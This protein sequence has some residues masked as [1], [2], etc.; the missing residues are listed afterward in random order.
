MDGLSHLKFHKNFIAVS[1]ETF[2]ST[3]S[4]V[5]SVILRIFLKILLRDYFIIPSENPSGRLLR[6]PSE[7]IPSRSSFWN[8]LTGYTCDF[9]STSFRVSPKI[10]SK[11]STEDPPPLMEF[12]SFHYWDSSRIF[13]R[14]YSRCFTRDFILDSCRVLYRY[15]SENQFGIPLA[16]PPKVRAWIAYE[17]PPGDPSEISSGILVFILEIIPGF[18]QELLL[19]L[20][21]ELFPGLL[22]ELLP[23][24]L[25]GSVSLVPPYSLTPSWIP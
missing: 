22:Q 18:L 21:Q 17:I 5:S 14:D 15:T 3:P 1:P 6:I 25:S 23:G 19:R 20:F 12:F 24:F 11:I 2:S 8:T 4:E 16:T 10:P 7:N 9:S 13:F